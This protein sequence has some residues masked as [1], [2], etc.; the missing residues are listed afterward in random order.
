[1]IRQARAILT[2][3]FLLS[4]ACSVLTFCINF[5]C[6]KIAPSMIAPEP[7]LRSKMP[8]LDSVRGVAIL[9]V[10]FYHGFF[11][12]NNLAGLSG[13]ARHFVS[14]TRFGWLGVHLFFVLSG[15]LITGILEDSK[16]A[17]RY[18]KR[19]YWRRALRILPA[20]YGTL[21]LL[22][23]LPGQAPTWVTPRVFSGPSENPRMPDRADAL[24]GELQ[25]CSE[26]QPRWD[27]LWTKAVVAEQLVSS[28]RRPFYRAHVL[29]M[30]A[31]GRES[32]QALLSVAEAVQDAEKGET[33]RA[34]TGVARALEALDEIFKAE[35]NAEYGKWK[36]WYRGDWLTGIQ[37]TREL[38]QIFAKQL[39]DPLSPMPPPVFWTGWEAYYHIMR[40]EGE[41]T[42]NVN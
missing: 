22:Y 4:C 15:F 41:R 21:L 26:A 8:E 11:W 38:V 14:L 37:R 10:V 30:I 2:T 29:A 18:F 42:A 6:C 27:A 36:G 24:K 12:S 40:Y 3:Y 39:E 23:F 13:V 16:S 1:M 33:A 20:F 9:A 19:F 25:R 17:P 7:L 5:R 28:E 34:R 31:I 32:N 35:Q